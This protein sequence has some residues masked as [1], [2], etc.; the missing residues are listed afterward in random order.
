MT[1]GAGREAE[2]KAW[3]SKYGFNAENV[4]EASESLGTRTYPHSFRELWCSTCAHTPL[5]EA[6][7][8]GRLDVVEFCLAKSP[9]SVTWLDDFRNSALHVALER[10]N[11]E[12]ARVLLRALRRVSD[13]HLGL[14]RATNAMGLTPARLSVRN[15]ASACAWCVSAGLF[16]DDD[17][18]IDAAAV[19]AAVSDTKWTVHIALLTWARETARDLELLEDGLL[20]LFGNKSSP[21][22]GCGIVR[23][24]LRLCVSRYS[25]MESRRIRAFHAVLTD[26]GYYPINQQKR[27]RRNERQLHDELHPVLFNR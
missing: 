4:D 15:N 10:G 8:S 3:M 6:S 9:E 24:Q 5:I 13:D 16:D 22:A 21:L 23:G 17:G 11:V 20:V 18:T 25:L 12:V 1:E 26:A 19:A 7:A 27:R 14:A 2:I